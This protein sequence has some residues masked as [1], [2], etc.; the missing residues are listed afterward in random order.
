MRPSATRRRRRP[1]ADS[2]EALAAPDD[3]IAASRSRSSLSPLQTVRIDVGSSTRTRAAKG[4]ERADPRHSAATSPD[5][6]LPPGPGGRSSPPRARSI[7]HLRC[8]SD[9]EPHVQSGAAVAA[10]PP[11]PRRSISLSVA[12]IEASAPPAACPSTPRC[13]PPWP[14][15]RARRNSSRAPRSAECSGPVARAYG[16]GT[17]AGA[18]RA[19]AHC[20]VGGRQ[21]SISRVCAAREPIA[22]HRASTD[23]ILGRRGCL[24]PPSAR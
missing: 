2:V 18:Q 4:V 22:V 5:R 1:R 12:R 21:E 8:A 3:E 16:R 6:P 19:C 14:P 9:R 24:V 10:R 20:A 13:A 11:R 15:L 7:D 23:R 17:A